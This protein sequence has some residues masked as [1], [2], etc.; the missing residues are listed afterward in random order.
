MTDAT[1]RI[2]AAVAALAVFVAPAAVALWKQVAQRIA[3]GQQ[4]GPKPAADGVA[5][6]DMRV[7]L[8]L[9]DRLRRVGCTDG[10]AL[11][12]QLL[13]VMLSPKQVKK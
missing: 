6:A 2:I 9:A 12:Q 11:C 10:V 13:D 4:A 7:V 8:D 1:I 3:D 5:V